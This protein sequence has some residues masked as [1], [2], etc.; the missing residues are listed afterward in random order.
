MRVIM[1]ERIREKSN[2]ENFS[3]YYSIIIHSFN[4]SF[5]LLFTMSCLSVFIV[6]S[7]TIVIYY[8]K[9]IVAKPISMYQ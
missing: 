7:L 1:K 2:Q 4:Y 5:I 9:E 6:V 8:S 3:S